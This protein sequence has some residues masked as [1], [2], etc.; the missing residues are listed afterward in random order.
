MSNIAYNTFR[1]DSDGGPDFDRSKVDNELAK[2]EG[3]DVN[4]LMSVGEI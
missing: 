2:N 4:V 1:K 3:K